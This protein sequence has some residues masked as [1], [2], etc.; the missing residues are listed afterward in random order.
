[1]R[2][3]LD[4]GTQGE[5][6][7]RGGAYR[8]NII[9]NTATGGVGYTHYMGTAGKFELGADVVGDT[10]LYSAKYT[11][12]LSEGWALTAGVN[13]L[14]GVINDTKAMVGLVWTPGAKSSYSR[15]TAYGALDAN[16]I[17][18]RNLS[19]AENDLRGLGS[20]GKV[21]TTTGPKT[22]TGSEKTGETAKA[23]TGPALADVTV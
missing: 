20:Y 8:N 14:A 7:L 15:P 5:L 11:K 21:E 16:K 13:H 4:V 23:P 10:K 19:S 12:P 6:S 17:V 22:L 2:G 3:V 9:G 1:M 18:A